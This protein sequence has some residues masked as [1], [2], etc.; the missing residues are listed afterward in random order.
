M[1]KFLLAALSVILCFVF[2]GCGG[3]KKVSDQQVTL[4]L[5][6]GDRSGT[7]TGEVND[8]NIP[9]G[10]GKFTTKNSKG[11]TWIYEGQFKD[12][13]FE[14]KGKETWPANGQTSEGTFAKDQLNGQGKMTFPNQPNKNYEGNFEAGVPMVAESAGLNEQVSFADWA[15]QVTQVTEQKSAGNK[16]ASGK[17]VVVV[18][19]DTNNGQEARQPGGGGFFVLFNKF[20]GAIYQTDDSATL[21][22]RQAATMAGDYNSPW[23]LSQVNPGNSVQGIKILFDIPADVP[24]GNLKFLPRDGFGVAKPIQLQ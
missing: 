22:V 14:G 24:I 4:N 20:N 7:Y 10:Q 3:P 2:I 13:H 19:N 11:E 5:S 6:F 15:Y 12:G 23:Y 17:Y 1:K 16:Q 8:Q 21:A 9:N 18:L